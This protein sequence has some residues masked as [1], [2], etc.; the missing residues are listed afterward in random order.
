MP[1]GPGECLA[2]TWQALVHLAR[3]QG[4]AV[5]RGDCASPEGS[6]TWPGRRIT[7]PGDEADQ[8]AV[9]ALAHQLGHVLLH[10]GVARL[11][12]GGTVPCH[13]T[14]KV[15]A[16]SVAYLIITHLGTG[17]PASP[18]PHVSSWAGTDSRAQPARTIHLVTDR[19]I[20][21]TTFI[22]RHLDAELGPVW[23]L[24]AQNLNPGTTT[25]QP[26]PAP[27]ATG[28]LARAHHA[29]AQFFRSQLPGSWVPAYLTARGFGAA[30]QERWQIGYAPAGWD[31]LTS[32]LRRAGYPD[33][34]IEAAGL[35]H[36]SQRG[37]LI[38][39]FRDRA[40]LPI[41]AADG[42]IVAFIGRAPADAKPGVP[43]YLNSPHTALYD[44]GSV[45]FGLYEARGA[46][47]NGARPVIVEGPFDAIAVS[48]A[49]RGRYAGLAPCGT[50]LTSRQLA[51]LA[52]ALN[53]EASGVSVAFDADQ[54]GRRA[55]LRAY[56]LLAQF[57][58]DVAL[59]D[60][61]AGQDAAQVLQSS[62]PRALTDAL[63][64]TQPLADLV[65]DAEIA[66]YQR[67]LQYPEGQVRALR[68]AAPLIAAMPPAGAARQASR[69]AELLDLPHSTVTEAIT[70]ALPDV[71]AAGQIP[72][73]RRNAAL[74]RL[75][76]GT[77][78]ATRTAGQDV[79][80]N[81]QTA[82]GQPGADAAPP[83]SAPR[84]AEPRLRRGPA[85]G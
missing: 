71:I 46:L 19:V 22:D 16:D 69:L 45:L 65:I 52:G 4:F 49:G 60:F 35:A 13:G 11:D 48:T 36:R 30:V 84:P 37:T 32:Y 75:P 17:E 56:P 85:P 14:R 41:H 33:R 82:I 9:T 6:I 66:R 24:P 63:S 28:Q 79:P 59:V 42:T 31:T 44:K 8:G 70:D 10:G 58:D 76:A 73:F 81:A 20:A 25:R 57:T 39:T 78:A 3:R 38:D 7:V 62:G 68:A 34:L 54:A 83:G 64:R 47:V 18:F 51:S 55:A 1:L 43:K 80:R 2:K 53:L 77:P 74:R 12:P 23:S 40:I 50:A 72:A 29:A 27:A 61:P 5:H 15:E 21:A 26:A 67:W